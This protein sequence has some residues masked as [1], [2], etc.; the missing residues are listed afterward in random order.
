MR[1]LLASLIPVAACR[2]GGAIPPSRFDVAP[3]T[4]VADGTVKT[5]LHIGYGMHWASLSPSHQTDV[6]LGLGY[7]YQG[8]GDED[9]TALKSDQQ[10]TKPSGDS[11][12]IIKSLDVH[13][14]YLEGDR[15]I[16]SGQNHRTWA[17]V[18]GEALLGSVDGRTRG[19]VGLTGR[20]SWEVFGTVKDRSAMGA[21]A[22]GAFIETG[23]RLLPDGRAGAQTLGGI[24][25]RLP[26]AATK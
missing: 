1:W 6:D 11:Y 26:A 21:F 5:G 12:R 24:T 23:V 17:G 8:F 25:V 2:S 3:V 18:R 14:I 13:A 19:G 22:I 7:I 20:L 9:V 4:M 15:R 10:P 16:G